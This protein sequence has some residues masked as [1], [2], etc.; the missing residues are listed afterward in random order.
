MPGREYSSS[1]KDALPRLSAAILR[2]GD[3]ID[4][5]PALLGHVSYDRILERRDW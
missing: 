2:A 5:V 3:E 4:L 1:R